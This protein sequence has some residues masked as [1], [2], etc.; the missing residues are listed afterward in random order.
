MKDTD[1]FIL[2]KSL[3]IMSLTLNNLL[4]EI[5]IDNK[6]V[7]APTLKAVMKA[8]GYLPKYCSMALSK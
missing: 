8:R 7:K 6:T 1:I 3:E 4:E 2:E 5:V